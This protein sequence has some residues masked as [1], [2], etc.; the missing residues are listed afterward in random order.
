[1]TKCHQLKSINMPLCVE[2]ST[3]LWFVAHVF[4]EC[5]YRELNQNA[6]KKKDDNVLAS[7]YLGLNEIRTFLVNITDMY[8]LLLIHCGMGAGEIC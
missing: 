3:S 7:D 5:H 4:R 8:P 1:M 6:T 2:S